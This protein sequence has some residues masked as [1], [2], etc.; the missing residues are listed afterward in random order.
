MTVASESYNL[1]SSSTYILYI[2]SILEQANTQGIEACP[3][4]YHQYK[5]D[6]EAN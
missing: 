4:S 2:T 3:V 1:H 5:V 6:Q